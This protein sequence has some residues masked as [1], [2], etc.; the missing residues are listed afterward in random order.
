MST[1][2]LTSP[3]TGKGSGGAV[4][5]LAAVAVGVYARSLGCGFINWDDPY[6]VTNNPLLLVLDW[7][8]L[9]AL[10]THMYGGLYIPL[11]FLSLGL[12][13]QLGG[14]NPVFYHAQSVLWNAI[15][16]VTFYF[17]ALRL[18]DC[19]RAGFLAALLFA[20]HPIHVES[21]AWVSE[22]KD[23][24]Y[25]TFL[26][27][28]LIAYDRYRERGGWPWYG[29]VLAAFLCSLLSKVAAVVFPLFLILLDGYRGRWEW[30]TRRV[31]E[32]LPFWLVSGFF[33][34][35]T[36]ISHMQWGN[37]R[38]EI[39]LVQRVDLWVSGVGMYL[40]KTFWPVQLS[41]LYPADVPWKELP[42]GEMLWGVL[43]LT[44]LSGYL[45]RA[46]HA[47]LVGFGLAFT[48]ISIV[49][50][51]A[52]AHGGQI[53]ADR[54]FY[55]GLGGI[56]L[57][58]AMTIRELN[59]RLAE[60]GYRAT[61]LA[62]WFGVVLLLG[63]LTAR[64]IQRQ[65]LWTSSLSLWQDAA[66]QFPDSPA[67][68]LNLAR[69]FRQ[70][71][72]MSASRAELEQLLKRNPDNG[73]AHM[74]LAALN[75][76]EGRISEGIAHAERARKLGTT[77]E[78]AA[79]LIL[80]SAYQEADNLAQAE[81]ALLLA[82]RLL[83]HQPEARVMLAAILFEQGR[84]DKMEETSLPILRRYPSHPQV[85]ALLGRVYQTQRRWAEA[86]RLYE[87]LLRVRPDD[88]EI[89]GSLAVCLQNLG[90]FSEA[91]R[92]LRLA[93]QVRPNDAKL[94]YQWGVSRFQQ[95]LFADAA[96]AFA[97]ALE[98]DPLQISA[99]LNRTAALMRMHQFDEAILAARRGLVVAPE[100]PR[101]WA[102]L[103]IS[104]ETLGQWDEAA[105]AWASAV[106]FD[107]GNEEWKSRL[108]AARNR[109]EKQQE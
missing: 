80:A 48:L 27:A 14:L 15:G 79:A 88:V 63:W 59:S 93:L 109:N 5:L 57:L 38:G 72:E 95:N 73:T 11:T 84:W 42:W 13:Y 3:A 78:Y 82:I 74:E 23:V 60:H 34:L 85:L 96:D 1:D 108:L 7:A 37:V 24:L 83:P 39:N 66:R 94:H 89:R 45:V 90:R 103:A 100:H 98:L 12:D 97:R 76:A 62:L 107:P 49:P 33:V 65:T 91:E 64:T 2:L 8:N 99:H 104:C 4:L 30:S 58:A 10:F 87:R 25:G 71:G 18:T 40:G 101:L 61:R 67:V 106:Q 6:Y 50:V 47:R 75:V 54:Y 68:R 81:K 77:N 55:V 44:V 21:V 92:Q 32:Y 52:I 56:A 102:N 51:Q 35:R 16:T 46:G 31:V 105:A 29:A 26:F 70:A 36:V 22:R 20:L 53:M 17:F 43:C 69:S 19:R 41:L 86:G 9:K 28:G